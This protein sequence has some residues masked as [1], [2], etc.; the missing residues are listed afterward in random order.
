MCVLKVFSETNSFKPFKEKTIIPVYS[1]CDKG[2]K[3]GRGH[4][5][6]TLYR[7]S[8]DVSKRDWDDF[9]GQVKDAI[10]FLRKYNYE[11]YELLNQYDYSDAY[12]DFPIYSRLTY[13]GTGDDIANQNDHLPHELITLAGGLHL[14]IEMAIY[15]RTAFT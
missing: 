7:I 3:R 5:V 2:E 9:D 15:A 6:Q 14:G 12:L 10:N 11:I 4:K 8:F 13:N 1:C